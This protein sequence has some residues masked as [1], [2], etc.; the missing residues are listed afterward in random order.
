MISESHSLS[1]FYAPIIA[2]WI[3][4]SGSIKFSINSLKN[5]KLAFYH[6]GLG[7]MPSTHTSIV[8]TVMFLVAFHEGVDSP[9]FSISLA[10]T[11]IVIIDAMDLR[12]KIGQHASIIKHNLSIS[13][14]ETLVLRE[15]LGH[16]YFEVLAGFLL[17]YLLAFLLYK[18]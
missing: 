2:Y 3:S 10:L 17:G 16:T 13:E 12:K 1:Y 8:T 15:R 14:S 4:V 9:F 6:I 7:G 11:I 18:I 5:K